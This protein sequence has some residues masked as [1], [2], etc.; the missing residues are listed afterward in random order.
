V[1]TKKPPWD[2]MDE[3]W[4]LAWVN[5]QLDILD[6]DQA[7]VGHE[8]EQDTLI[9]QLVSLPPKTLHKLIYNSVTSARLNLWLR[10]D[11]AP[12]R[13]QFPEIAEAMPPR[14]RQRRRQQDRADKHLLL[15]SAI[16]DVG[17]IRA[18][19]HDHYDSRRNRTVSPT[20]VRLAALRN[21]VDE[22]EL[23]EAIRRGL[24]LSDKNHHK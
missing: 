17:R 16:E 21:G 3:R 14:W 6:I 10:G 4:W 20:P 18:L 19:Y 24:S 23:E 9:R 1:T 13:R 5:E 8:R 7:G 2:S 22:N 11:G 12:L 15:K